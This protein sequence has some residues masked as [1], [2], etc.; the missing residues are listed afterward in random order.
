[1]SFT[2]KIQ[3]FCKSVNHEEAAE[4]RQLFIDANKRLEN[5]PGAMTMSLQKMKQEIIDQSFDWAIL[6]KTIFEAAKTTHPE[7]ET[8][9][10]AATWISLFNKSETISRLSQVLAH[11]FPNLKCLIR[12]LADDAQKEYSSLS[13]IAGGMHVG[14]TLASP[15]SKTPNATSKHKWEKRGIGAAEGLIGAATVNAS[16]WS[17]KERV[18]ASKFDKLQKEALE[19]ERGLRFERQ[20]LLEKLDRDDADDKRLAKLNDYFNPEIT[21]KVEF[22]SDSSSDYSDGEKLLDKGMKNGEISEM[23]AQQLSDM[24]NIRD[25]VN[26]RR[27]AHNIS[28]KVS[29]LDDFSARSSADEKRFSIS[30]NSSESGFTSSL[31]NLTSYEQA[32]VE[33]GLANQT[34][35]IMK[36][37]ADS[38]SETLDDVS[39]I[40]EDMI[41]N[42]L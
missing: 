24:N 20:E 8:D 42:A 38:A 9:K 7:H 1:M 23:W 10:F 30:S 6:E 11:D 21:A 15:W 14:K 35:N 3:K 5:E 37:A 12:S 25:D 2:E 41:D 17:I 34:D 32:S 4:L 16:I 19:K 26:L 29:D 18:E 28:R 27:L 31:D 22:S 36:S 33:R 39:S 13:T 40:E